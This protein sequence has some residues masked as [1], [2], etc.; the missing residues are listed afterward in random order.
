MRKVGLAL[1]GAAA[2]AGSS[3]ASAAI[4]FAG[5]TQG[6]L[7]LTS[8]PCTPGNSSSLAGLT[9]TTGSFDQFTSANGF[10][11]IGSGN[12]DSLGYFSQD[13]SANSYF[14]DFFTLLVNFTLPS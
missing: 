12:T 13:G 1:I 14:G 9:F 8:A 2:L 7:S 6:C 10:A 3:A 11:A 4:E 5:T